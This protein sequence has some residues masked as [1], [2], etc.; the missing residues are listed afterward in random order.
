MKRWAWLTAGLGL[1]AVSLAA[2]APAWLLDALLDD[3]SAGRVRLASAAGTIWSGQATAELRDD[4]GGSRWTA[5]LAW[6]LLPASLLAGR[7][8]YRLVTAP[9][10]S[11]SAM[12]VSRSRVEFSGVDIRMPAARLA[13]ALPAAAPWGVDGEVRLLADRVAFGPAHAAGSITV[14]WLAAGS[15]LS[16]VSPLGDYALE[17]AGDAQ[18][19]RARLHTLAG[20]VQL[21]GQ[22]AWR[23]GDRPAFEAT[24]EVP[25]ALRD[26]LAPFLRLV[27]IERADGRFEW[28]LR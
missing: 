20:P 4:T 22:G 28:R 1:Y 9:E 14:H 11:L 18:G 16:P 24:A 19:W 25:P 12:S 26:E 7:L 8:D 23:S 6:R 13:A 3:A 17:I 10:T 27:A 15:T 21:S 5:P 2:L